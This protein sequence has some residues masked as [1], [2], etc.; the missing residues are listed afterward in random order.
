M[1]NHHSKD[2]SSRSPVIN[3]HRNEDKHC[4]GC[5]SEGGH[6]YESRIHQ[7]QVWLATCLETHPQ[8]L[9][10]QALPPL[11]TRVLDLNLLDDTDDIRLIYGD[12][13][14]ERYAALTYCW[15]PPPHFKTTSVNWRQNQSRI[16]FTDL[17]LLF[18]ET[19]TLLRSLGIPYLWIDALCIIQDSV[20]DW[21]AESS[22][23][24]AVY[25]NA[26]LTISASMASSPHRPLYSR[27]VN[28]IIQNQS[29]RNM[30]TEVVTDD[31][32][33]TRGWCLQER[34]LSRR[35]V[36]FGRDQL[37]WEC[38]GATCS[39]HLPR[40]SPLETRTEAL[41][42]PFRL[43]LGPSWLLSPSTKRV[44]LLSFRSTSSRGKKSV[45]DLYYR[46]YTIMHDYTAR[47]LTFETDRI[48]AMRGLATAF[49]GAT[50]DELITGLWRCDMPFG[51]LWHRPKSPD[52]KYRHGFSDTRMP[53]W[54]WLSVTGKVN[55]PFAEDGVIRAQSSVK[56]VSVD[57]AKGKVRLEGK[58]FQ[59]RP[60]TW[61]EL[62]EFNIGSSNLVG[63]QIF[64]DFD[65]ASR[66]PENISVPTALHER[67]DKI[68]S[69]K[70]LRVLVIVEPSN[71]IGHGLMV[72]KTAE[73]PDTYCRVG[74]V[75]LVSKG[76]HWRTSET[77]WAISKLPL[78]VITLE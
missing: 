18:R 12:G 38:P 1:G 74:Y 35:V 46:W 32:L 24:A 54:S 21:E 5:R 29:L 11:P 62:L 14:R 33:S 40:V 67:L 42:K 68:K 70:K 19:V 37:H 50:G 43:V 34:C 73:E 13:R 51:L 49:E 2:S 26:H 22:K 45:S 15:G 30:T 55:W 28:G 57:K 76:Y 16:K 44:P 48:P 75:K 17:N 31:V 59:Y 63:V 27:Q 10:P 52:S 71:N 72:L 25:S 64:W 61:N 3:G 23:M 9:W 78:R 4:I 60:R 56:I 7:I 66:F 20:P 53:S 41:P 47:L 58:L 69:E 39:E 65:L 77:P 36:H 6:T 8:C